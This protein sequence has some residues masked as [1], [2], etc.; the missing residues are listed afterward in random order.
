MRLLNILLNLY[1]EEYELNL[2][3]GL[4]KTT[5]VGEAI[6]IIKKSFP[7]WF[8]Q[9]DKGDKDFTIEILRIKEGIQPEYFEKLLPLLNN[10]GYFIS[11][12][13]IYSNWDPIT[14]NAVEI[15][16]KYNEKIVKNAFQNPKTHSIYLSCEAKFDQKVNKIPEFLYHVAPL[17]NWEK[18]QQTGLVPKSR[19]K[20]AYHPER[21]YLGKDEKSTIDLAS[22][23]YQTTGLKDWILLQIDTNTVPGD[24]LKLYYDP[25]YKYGY[26]TLNNIPPQSIEKIKDIKL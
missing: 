15:K 19:S 2:K 24:Y 17:R 20:K 7:N 18:I 4:I 26:Y 22:K 1:K 8:F 16:D 12:I 21:V 25:N 11:Y 9:Y 5:P 10:L 6:N 14:K 13:E 3:E 23:F